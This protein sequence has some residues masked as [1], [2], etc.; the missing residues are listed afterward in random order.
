VLDPTPARPRVQAEGIKL[1]RQDGQ[2]FTL[3]DW[4]VEGDTLRGKRE[5]WVEYAPVQQ[6]ESIALSD[7]TLEDGNLRGEELRM[8]L[9]ERERKAA[10][11]DAK[12]TSSRQSELPDKIRIHLADGRIARMDHARVDGD[13]LRGVRT[14]IS[15]AYRA[16]RPVA[17]A[18]K[19]VR[20]I[21]GRRFDTGRTLGLVLLGGLL[22]LGV[23]I[24]LYGA[25][26][27][28]S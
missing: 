26:I 20:A 9:E 23:F 10:A 13:S 12:R 8:A 4:I 27:S 15:G 22:T 16:E 19:D 24:A 7:V 18:L 25:A 6:A 5:V 2:K 21:E 1:R 17:Y 14:T 3:H 28:G 11:R